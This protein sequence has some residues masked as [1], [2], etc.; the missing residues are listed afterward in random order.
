MT[1]KAGD[2]KQECAAM[3]EYQTG[4]HTNLMSLVVWGD[5]NP[6]LRTAFINP[7]GHQATLV[8]PGSRRTGTL[9]IES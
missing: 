1:P 3:T 9:M 8:E 5:E 2:L 6:V 4:L 7:Q